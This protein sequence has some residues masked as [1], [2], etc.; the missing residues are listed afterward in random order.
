LEERLELEKPWRWCGRE[1]ERERAPESEAQKERRIKR[2][3]GSSEHMEEERWC[4]WDKNG[5][6]VVREDGAWKVL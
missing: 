5:K 2:E 3:S 4:G 1:R 6:E